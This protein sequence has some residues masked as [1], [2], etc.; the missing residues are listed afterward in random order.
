MHKAVRSSV[1]FSWLVLFSAASTGA[2][3]RGA[4]PDRPVSFDAEVS[5]CLDSA[6]G[7]LVAQARASFP[8]FQRR[9]AAGLPPGQ[10]PA[11][12]VRLND[13]SGHWEQVF[14]VVDSIRRDSVF[15]RI[16]SDIALVRGYR[17]G[18]RLNVSTTEILD[19]T[20]SR[21]DGTEEGNLLGKFMDDLQDRLRRAPQR[22]PC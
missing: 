17:R 4:P 2:Q 7:P 18:Q 9:V 5:A 21:P 10:L 19:W 11:V 3:Q 14:V 20:I 6:I 22:K 1:L 12:T 15:G 8:D 13:V 16:N